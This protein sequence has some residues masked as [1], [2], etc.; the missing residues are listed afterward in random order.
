[1]HRDIKPSNVLVTGLDR[2]VLLD[3]G[4]ALDV[5]EHQRTWTGP[6]IIGTP[7]YMSPEQ[8]AGQ[9]AGPASDWY[10][11]GVILYEA[12]TGRPPHDGPMTKILADKQSVEPTPPIE[13]DPAL[14]ADLS[15][16]ATALLRFAPAERPTSATALHLLRR[17]RSRRSSKRILGTPTQGPLFVGRNA[18]LVRLRGALDEV[19]RIGAPT[20]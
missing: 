15:T 13:L 16:L 7:H 9:P 17:E 2:V 18:E 6:S 12:L 8:A 5:E 14:P 11:A 19:E 10:S 1:V 4:L 20:A 3:F